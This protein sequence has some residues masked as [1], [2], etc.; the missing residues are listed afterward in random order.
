MVIR[1]LKK[2]GNISNTKDE[3]PSILSNIFSTINAYI[4]RGYDKYI[5]KGNSDA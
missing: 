4:H 1:F 5:D 3:E 2:K